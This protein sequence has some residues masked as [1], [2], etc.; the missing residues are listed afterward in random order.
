MKVEEMSGSQYVNYILK[1]S[2]DASANRADVISNNMANV[3]VPGYKRHYVTFEETLDN[4]INNSSMKLTREKHINTGTE[5]GQIKEQKD[6]STSIRADGNNVDL[7]N[8]MI[9]NAANALMY[10]AVVTQANSRMATTK[11]VINGK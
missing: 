9:N 10:N 1:K 11:Y 3:N 2:M 4:A 5:F 7:E 8:E 6:N